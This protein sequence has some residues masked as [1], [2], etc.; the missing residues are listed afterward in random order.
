MLADS[1]PLAHTFIWPEYFS[2]FHSGPE[3]PHPAFMCH[4]LALGRRG[5][6]WGAQ[7][8]CQPPVRLCQPLTHIYSD[9]LNYDVLFTIL[10]KAAGCLPNTGA[11]RRKGE[12]G[13][14]RQVGGFLLQYIWNWF[15]NF[16][17]FFCLYRFVCAS[18][19]CLISLCH[20]QGFPVDLR[21]ALILLL[22]MYPSL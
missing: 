1:I 2:V 15:F 20:R 19:W 21:M 22:R 4:A 6:T 5:H 11:R 13:G 17:I 12:G 9:E 3:S 16:S 18:N 10:A 14:F 8:A 7:R